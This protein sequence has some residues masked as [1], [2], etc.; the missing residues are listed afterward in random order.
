MEDRKKIGEIARRL[1][2]T[3]GVRLIWV[4]PSLGTGLSPHKYCRRLLKALKAQVR[5]LS[6][7]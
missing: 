4:T 1:V 6:I 3:F 7:S 5:R 2:D